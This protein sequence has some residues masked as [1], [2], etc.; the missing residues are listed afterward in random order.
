MDV[1]VKMKKKA[2]SKQVLHLAKALDE[3]KAILLC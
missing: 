3:S 1:P 2:F